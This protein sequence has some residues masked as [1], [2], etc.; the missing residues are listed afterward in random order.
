MFFL[1]YYRVY[2]YIFRGV[3]RLVSSCVWLPLA[4]R[5][6]RAFVLDNVGLV[7]GT[8]LPHTLIHNMIDSVWCGCRSFRWR[9]L[10]PLLS[11]NPAISRSRVS[12]QDVSAWKVRSLRRESSPQT[13]NTVRLS[14][15]CGSMGTE[16]RG[17]ARRSFACSNPC[18]AAQSVQ[19]T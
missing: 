18:G 16:I 7:F 14:K 11:S 17:R 6:E 9:Y 15:N 5:N 13:L 1:A 19:S 3:L 4:T 8:P 2:A 10:F 12:I